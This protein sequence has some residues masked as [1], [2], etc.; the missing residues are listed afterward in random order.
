MGRFFIRGGA[1]LCG[2]ISVG[3]SKNA[4]LPIIFSCILICGKSTIKNLPDITD[5]DVALDILADFGASIQRICDGVIIDTT[6]LYYRTPD[7]EK[8]SKIRASAYLIGACLSRFGRAELQSFGGCNFDNRPI[9]MHLAAATLHGA[10]IDGSLLYAD[11]LIG[12][13]VVFDKISVGATVNALLLSASAL[14]TS[15]IYGYAR[16]PHVM[17]LI[18]FLNRAGGEIE[19]CDN[20]ITVKGRALTSS[21]ANI[22]SDMIEAG[23]Y[24]SLSL[25]TGSK[26]KVV[27]A[28]ATELKSFTHPLVSCGANLEVSEEGITLL[29]NI[30]KPIHIV[31]APYP[32]FPT[33]LQ[34]LTSPVMARFFGGVIFEGVWRNRF[35]YLN[36]LAKFG[37]KF[38]SSDGCAVIHKSKLHPAMA[39]ATDLRCGAALI[40]AALCAD[41]ESVIEDSDVIKRGYSDI[42]KK[43][44][45]IGAQIEEF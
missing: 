14:G 1:E 38:E 4:A 5:V 7:I 10:K 8:V 18:D 42:V 15:R 16:E 19:V 2:E 27:G 26:L 35:G 22:I 6:E 29:G 39:T 41:G 37:L 25:A 30:S 21:D 40:I 13:D 36:E 11:R 3:G 23:S 17:S 24:L 31:T 44:R 32:A 9:D 12:A 34:P 33:D 28:D 20:C 43:L 45:G